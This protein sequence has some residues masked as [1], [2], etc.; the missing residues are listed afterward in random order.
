MVANPQ[1]LELWTPKGVTH[2]RVTP[3][4]F[5]QETGEPIYEYSFIV[6]DEVTNRK[7]QFRVLVDDTTSKAHIEEMVANAMERWLIDVRIRHSKPAPTP[8]Q[9]KE[10]GKILNQIRTNRIKRN[11]S[12]NNKIYYKGLR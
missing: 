8:E 7:E 11:G 2:K 12:S 4:G 3:V 6:H 9:K 5:N 1:E 10:I